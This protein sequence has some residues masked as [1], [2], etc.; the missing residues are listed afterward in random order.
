MP[1]HARPHLVDS[2]CCALLAALLLLA[3][4]CNLPLAPGYTVRVETRDVGFVPDR[5][6]RL[7]I[8]C[9][10][11]LENS[12]TTQ[13]EFMD[14]SFP[15]VNPFG[16][17]DIQA[18][19]DGHPVPLAELPEEYRPESPDTLRLVFVSPWQHG[20]RHEL[21]L[22][23]QLSSP[24]DSGS[25]ISIG[26]RT[27]HLGPRGW[28]ALP[29]PPHHFLSP[30]PTRPPKMT[31]SIRVP[32]DFLVLARGKLMSRKTVGS[33]TDYVFGLRKDDLAPYVVAGH[34]VETA[35][36]SSA[37]AVVFWTLGPLTQNPGPMPNRL[38]QA[39]A[40]LQRD[41]GPIDTGVHAPHLVECPDLDS[42]AAPGSRLVATSFPGGALVNRDLLGLGIA[43][44]EFIERV[45]RALARDWFGSQIYPTG[46]AALGMG[47]GLPEYATIVIDEAR[48][49]L[50]ARQRRVRTYLA[51]YDRAMKN[52]AEK[53]LGVTSPADPPAE[54]A[55]A[56]SK[57]PLMYAA[58][59]DTCGQKAVHAGLKRLVATLHGQEVGFD[60][61]R[62]AIEQVCG[63]DLGPFFRQWLY[64]SGLPP[65]FRSRYETGP[66]GPGSLLSLSRLYF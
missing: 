43:S 22:A 14:I 18:Q 10:Y 39:W 4:G 58:L 23:Y 1:K 6:A 13:L 3:S 46:A 8:H 28:S 7:E 51:R 59:E 53:P 21:D 26:E 15:E 49:G 54:S 38:A 20:E 52:G 37:G 47:E 63:R 33:E 60:D 41:F 2:W 65:D 66:M 5:P 55:I 30:Y 42:N 19:W 25:R 34:Y 56:L 16:R 35:F 11:L 62:A 48:S 12:G 61:L 32:S 24:R 45:S 40:V 27:F 17:K 36:H 31:Y 50:T 29:Q 44:D 9:H 57:A 64:G